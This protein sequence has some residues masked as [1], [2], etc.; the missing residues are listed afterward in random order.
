MP[1][2]PPLAATGIGSVPFTSKR[3]AL[4]LIARAC[5]ALPYW[6]QLVKL[7]PQE[8]F[9]LQN[10]PGLPLLEVDLATRSITVRRDGREEALTRFY[11]H[12]LAGDL[13]HFALPE[14]VA[15][16]F[17]AM[18]ERAEADAN[19]G[20]DFLKGQL[21]GPVSF[22]ESIRDEDGKTIFNDPELAEV[23]AL[24]L[25]MR[26]AWQASRIRAVGRRAVI[27]MDEPGLT[28]FGSAFS[29]LDRKT[30]I[31]T[32][33]RA[34]GAARAQGELLIGTHICGNTDWD[35]VLACDLDI[36]NFDAYGFLDHFLLFP[37][38]IAA[39]LERGGRLAWGITPT[40]D[41]DGTQTP[42]ELSSRLARGFK[43]LAA[44]GL[45]PELIRARSLITPACGLGTLSPRHASE[46]LALN[47]ECARLMAQGRA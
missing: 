14:A 32:I 33:N 28:G 1:A 39:F 42:G 22:G 19:F 2:L 20:P 7:G 25:G 12:F 6:P 23:M 46:I 18:L 11:E 38:A 16:G 37:R 43:K 47:F 36:I 21:P 27:F 9:I 8:D 4:D 17:Y 35:M 13:E 40:V 3:E 34:A 44:T 24:G 31:E 45:D 29:T 5:P 15:G 26:A 41:Y 10:A 30:V